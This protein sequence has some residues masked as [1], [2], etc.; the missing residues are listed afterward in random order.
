MEEKQYKKKTTVYA[1]DFDG[2][3]TK[4]DTLIAFI[5][6]ACGNRRFYLAMALFITTRDPNYRDAVKA[7]RQ[8]HPDTPST[9]RRLYAIVK[10]IKA[11]KRKK[12]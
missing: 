4:K 1:F 10:E 9:F 7:W 11:K 3:L 8:S 6:Y 12:K 5:R 2:T